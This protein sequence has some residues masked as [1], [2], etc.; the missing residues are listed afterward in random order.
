MPEV[1][2]IIPTNRRN[3]VM[4]PKI[5]NIQS[6]LLRNHFSRTFTNEF[7]DLITQRTFD[8]NH[9]LEL[10]LSSLSYQTFKDFEVIISHRYPEDALETVKMEWGFPIKLVKEKPSIWHDLGEKYPTLCNNI[11]TGVIH[12]SGEL[13]WRLDDLTFFNNR[14]LEE[15]WSNWKN[16]YYST[17]RGFRCIDFEE[18]CL[19]MKERSVRVGP[20]KYNCY[21]NGWLGQLKPLTMEGNE[22]PSW[23]MWGFSSTMSIDDF[24]EVNGQDEIY[25][26]SISGTDIE[27]AMRIAKIN[28]QRRLATQNFVYE[29]NDVPYKYM[30]RDDVA[31]RRLWQVNNLTANDWKPTEK[32]MKLYERWHKKKLGELDEYWNQF[33]NVPYLDMKKEY[34]DKK[35]G[36]IVYES[37]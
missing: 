31:M 15:L 17:S 18:K 30:A 8:V 13:L 2:I 21:Y 7:I 32:Q 12:S 26:G 14:A 6:A 27:I 9:Y 16:G 4:I 33:M 5:R 34:K 1:S 11:N 23:M 35:L 29:I 37:E 36:K 19:G 20:N 28:K 24:L 3:K 22:I 25:D 10:T